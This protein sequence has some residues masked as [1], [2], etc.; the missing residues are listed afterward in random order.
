MHRPAIAR[1]VPPST[2][3]PT[4]P[5]TPFWR[6]E[7]KTTDT[8]ELMIYDEVSFYGVTAA[9]FAKAKKLIKY[10]S[11][12]ISD[13]KDLA[14]YEKLLKNNGV[15]NW[16]PAHIKDGRFGKWLE[17]ARD[18]AISRSRF[19][20][21]PLPVWKA[22]DGER[23]GPSPTPNRSRRASPRMR[24]FLKPLAMLLSGTSTSK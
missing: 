19:W 21:T 1:R 10:I 5:V 7:N 16:V 13:D 22:E 18:W 3:V 9:D 11:I 24:R 12:Y 17:G 4:S 15:I 23:L 2:A 14:K 8:A 6:I 20:G